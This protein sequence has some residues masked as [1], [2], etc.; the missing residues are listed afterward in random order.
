MFGD[1]Q[2]LVSL[3]HHKGYFQ[4]SAKA[5]A[6]PGGGSLASQNCRIIPDFRTTEHFAKMGNGGLTGK[7]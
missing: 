4:G 7:L 2:L 6:M 5:Q 3:L 1:M